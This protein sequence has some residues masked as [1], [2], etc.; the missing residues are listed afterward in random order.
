VV[1]LPEGSGD[2]SRAAG[3]RPGELRERVLDLVQA[4]LDAL[5]DRDLAL[6]REQLHRAHLAHVHAHRVRGAAGLFDRR[7]YR[8]RF[9]RRRLVVLG[10]RGVLQQQR[11]GIG[12]NFVHLDAHVVDHVD[13][14]FDLLRIDDV[15]GEVIVDLGVGQEALFL[16]LGDELLDVGSSL[17]D[18]LI[19]ADF[20]HCGDSGKLDRPV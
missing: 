17:L 11:L 7:Q 16:A 13:D 20:G 5:G 18:G 1:A 15:V 3:D 6:A 10:G 2:R 12:R 14:V 19:G 4:F 9:F 8:H